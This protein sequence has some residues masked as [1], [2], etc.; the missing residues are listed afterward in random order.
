M[1]PEKYTP[2]EFPFGLG[3]MI[4]AL[5]LF[6]FFNLIVAM[7]VSHSAFG[8]AQKIFF[9]EA[10][11]PFAVISILFTWLKK[12]R[13]D[14]RVIGLKTPAGGLFQSTMLAIVLATLLKVVDYSLFIASPTHLNWTP[15]P[16][17]VAAVFPFIYSIG[18]I[19]VSPFA[20]EL[21]FRSLLFGYL[22][23]RLGWIAGLLLQAAIFAVVHPQIYQAGIGV[24]LIYFSFGLA[25]G[26]LYHHYD[27]LYPAVLCHACL[28]YI[29]TFL[30]S[31]SL[32]DGTHAFLQSP[33]LSVFFMTGWG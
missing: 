9:V 33:A 17:L 6:L 28:N 26:F 3:D 8:L 31:L 10:V 32:T 22:R 2:R 11:I 25:F 15:Y 23:A 5:G 7:P 19:V 12:R 29:G 24:L 14:Y 27:S 21:V 13:T 16:V 1:I 20:E 30:H 4:F 18:R